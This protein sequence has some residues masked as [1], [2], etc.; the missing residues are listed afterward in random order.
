MGCQK[1]SLGHNYEFISV[2]AFKV[3]SHTQRT[4]DVIVIV[5]TY[6]K[7]LR[8]ENKG[9]YV[10]YHDCPINYKGIRKCMEASSELILTRRIYNRGIIVVYVVA[11]DEYFT[12]ENIWQ[13]YT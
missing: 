12:K 13:S 5:K 2:N 8:T 9:K 1:N 4:V 11:Y 7:C 6:M 3:G 10:E